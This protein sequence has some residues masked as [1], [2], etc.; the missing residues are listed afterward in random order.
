MGL[1]RSGILG[2]GML[3][4]EMGPIPNQTSQFQSCIDPGLRELLSRLS[5]YSGDFFLTDSEGAKAAK[6]E[7]NQAQTAKGRACVLQ[8]SLA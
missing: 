3:A 8:S 7:T 1:S 2:A 5:V 6:E 4:T